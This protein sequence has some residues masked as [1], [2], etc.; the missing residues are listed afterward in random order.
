V[1]FWLI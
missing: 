1:V